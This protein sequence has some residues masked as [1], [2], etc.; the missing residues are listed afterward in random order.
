MPLQQAAAKVI[1]DFRFEK[2]K[3]R[4]KVVIYINTQKNTT[5]KYAQMGK[6]R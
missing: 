6:K 2:I 4:I 3:T 5:A 1:A